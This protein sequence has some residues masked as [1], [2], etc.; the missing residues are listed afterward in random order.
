VRDAERRRDHPQHVLGIELR[1][2]QLRRDQVLALQLAKQVAYQRR[3]A[4]TDFPSD[5]DEPFPLVQSILEVGHGPL[6][7]LAAI[8]EVRI[9]VEL[10]W[11]GAQFVEGFVHM[12]LRLKSGHKFADDCVLTVFADALI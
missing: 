7:T 6:V 8:E 4:R 3:L 1:A 10:K 9:G 2:D 5:N 11:L 12:S